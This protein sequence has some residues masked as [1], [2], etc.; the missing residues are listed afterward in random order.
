MT[1]V[2][3]DYVAVEYRHRPDTTTSGYYPARMVEP[4][5]ALAPL[6]TNGAASGPCA[7]ATEPTEA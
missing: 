7:V 1:A 3:G 4:A 6:P 5:P 2:E